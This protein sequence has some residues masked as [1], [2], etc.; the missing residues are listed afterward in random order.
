MNDVVL[1][2]NLAI[3]N[4]NGARAVG[5]GFVA[6]DIVRGASGTFSSTGGSCGNVLA[7][8]AWMGWSCAPVIRLGRD[9]A[10]EIVRREMKDLGMNVRHVRLSPALS[11]PIV[12]QNFVDDGAGGAKHKFSRICPTCEAPFARFQSMDL[13][14]AQRAMALEPPLVFYF[15]RTSAPILQVAA[16]AKASGALLLFEPATLGPKTEFESAIELC[17]ILKFSEERF[18]GDTE[19]CHAPHP[20]LVVQTLGAKGLRAR[21]NG[22]W[23]FQDAQQAEAIVDAAGAGD[24]C[25]AGLLNCFGLA[26]AAEFRDMDWTRIELALHCGQVLAAR[27]CVYEGARGLMRSTGVS[28]PRVVEDPGGSCIPG[29]GMRFCR[30]ETG[31]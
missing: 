19:L 26:R 16:W 7:A 31:S 27:N 11:T 30:R 12:I 21:W 23:R 28:G 29:V 13:S 6:L 24:W 14:Q 3:E 1:V 20:P 10:G 2:S 5:A 4:A 18:G 15:D 9:E 22:Q 8:L 25:S 17:D